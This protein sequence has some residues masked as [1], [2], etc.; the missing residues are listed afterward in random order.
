[1]QA[2]EFHFQPPDRPEGRP[3]PMRARETRGEPRGLTCVVGGRC[4]MEGRESFVM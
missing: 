2:N 3:A 1:M 4:S